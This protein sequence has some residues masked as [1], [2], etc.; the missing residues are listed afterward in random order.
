MSSLVRLP[1]R[2]VFDSDMRAVYEFSDSCCV[3]KN[4]ERRKGN[5]GDALHR[6]ALYECLATCPTLGLEN[7]RL[8]LHRGRSGTKEKGAKIR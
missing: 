6:Q 4:R 7:K 5:G 2:T 3:A 1:I 8:V